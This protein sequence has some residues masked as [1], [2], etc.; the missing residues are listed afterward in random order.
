MGENNRISRNTTF[1]K[2]IN[3]ALVLLLLLFIVPNS[4]YGYVG[5]YDGTVVIDPIRVESGEEYKFDC[6]GNNVER[7]RIDIGIRPV[8]L[9][10]TDWTI[11]LNDTVDNH[12]IEINSKLVEYNKY[13]FDHSESVLITIKID[14]KEVL[15]KDFGNKLPITRSPI[16]LRTI[17]DGNKMTFFAGDGVLN[18]V[19]RINYRGFVDKA[20]VFSKYDIIIARYASLFEPR[21]IIPQVYE[22]E[23]AIMAALNQCSDNNCG[24]WEYFDEEVETKIAVRGG[25]Y[26]VAV[27]PSAEGG[28]DIIYLSGAEVDPYRWQVGYLKGYLIPTPFANTFTLYWRDSFGKEINDQSPYATFDGIIMSLTFPLQ[29]AKFRFV[30]SK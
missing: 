11:V 10:K 14:G 26:K 13:D 20:I 4:G 23:S 30:K 15:K 27:L 17:F 25:R 1:C 29:K 19:E 2:G 8:E 12:D 22:N 3:L 5:I 9:N 28:Y 7:Q 6:I 18:I 21:P 24:I 16:Y